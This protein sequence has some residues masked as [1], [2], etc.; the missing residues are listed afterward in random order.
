MNKNNN[1]KIILIETIIMNLITT[2]IK[3]LYTK[4]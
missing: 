3:L 4:I 2:N 1:K